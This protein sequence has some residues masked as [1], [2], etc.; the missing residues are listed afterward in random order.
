[1][2]DQCKTLAPIGETETVCDGSVDKFE[3]INKLRDYTCNGCKIRDRM[4]C[5]SLVVSADD[6]K[7][8]LRDPHES[9]LDEQF[10][11]RKTEARMSDQF[12]WP[13]MTLDIKDISK[14]CDKCQQIS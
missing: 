7:I 9:H 3:K 5:K 4:G 14:L 11:F 10:S 13:T 12:C 6:W 2:L 1:M 8:V